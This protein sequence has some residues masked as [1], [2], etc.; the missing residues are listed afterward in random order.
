[1]DTQI[2]K[3]TKKKRRDM[4]CV[5]IGVIVH[6]LTCALRYQVENSWRFGGDGRWKLLVILVKK[7]LGAQERAEM[8]ARTYVYVVP[9][10]EEGAVLPALARR[11]KTAQCLATHTD[12]SS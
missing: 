11:R 8:L 1:M 7:F 3:V 6:S 10:F 2:T 4:I 5:Q 9:S 12:C